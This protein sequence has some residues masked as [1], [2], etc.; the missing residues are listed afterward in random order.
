MFTIT[1]GAVKPLHVMVIAHGFCEYQHVIHHQ[2]HIH[3][4]AQL[5]YSASDAGEM[6][7]I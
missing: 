7:G 1:M 6:M 3:V 5:V 4:F 2:T